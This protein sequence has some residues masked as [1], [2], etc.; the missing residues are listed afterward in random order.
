MG[1]AEFYLQNLEIRL[2]PA[3]PKENPAVR[4]TGRV[5][6]GKRESGGLRLRSLLSLVAG[7][8]KISLRSGLPG[9]NSRCTINSTHIPLALVGPNHTVYP[10]RKKRLL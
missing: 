10:V 3:S 1:T 8:E 4:A 9:F 2:R 7:L 5:S 6:T